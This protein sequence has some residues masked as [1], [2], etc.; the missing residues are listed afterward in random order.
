[1]FRAKGCARCSNG[2]VGRFAILETLPITE[3]VKRMVI[4]GRSSIEVRAKAIEQGMITLRRAAL[5]NAMRGNTS[6]EEVLRVTLGEQ[7]AA[8]PDAIK[9][10]D[11][12]D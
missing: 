3:E 6:I 11:T 12:G 1:V 7:V 9:T 10:A 2:Y 4:D 5:L 8:K